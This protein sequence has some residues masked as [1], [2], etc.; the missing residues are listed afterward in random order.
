MY[1]KLN[2]IRIQYLQEVNDDYILSEIPDSTMSYEKPILVRTVDELTSWFGNRFSSYDYFVELLNRDISLYIYRPVNT[3]LIKTDDY[4]DTSNYQVDSTVYP[5]LEY[6]EF[7]VTNPNPTTKYCVGGIH[8][9]WDNL[10]Y[11]DL[12]RTEF[13]EEP[14]E[15]YKYNISGTWYTFISGTWYSEYDSTGEYYIYFENTWT[16]L[17]DLPQ[18]IEE[19]TQSQ[20]NRDTLVI[21][22]PN[23]SGTI[24]Y[25]YPEYHESELGIYSDDTESVIDIDQTYPMY[26]DNYV[27]DIRITNQD[28]FS[29]SDYYLILPSSWVIPEIYGREGFWRELTDYSGGE[30][31]DFPETHL[32]NTKY[33]INSVW[34]TWSDTLSIWISSKD[35]PGKPINY[36]IGYGEKMQLIPETY[37][38]SPRRIEIDDEMDILNFLEDRLGYSF[39][40]RLE[41]SLPEESAVG[42]KCYYKGNE[43]PCVMV[44]TKTESGWDSNYEDI[45]IYSSISLDIIDSYDIP[46]FSIESNKRESHI[47]LT[48]NLDKSN[49]GIEVWSKTIGK[50]DP[51]Y[52]TDSI[53]IQIEEV[54]EKEIYQITIS[55][56]D[57][58]ETYE[59]TLYPEA[60]EERLD[61]RI[62]R[63]SK[64]VYIRFDDY[65]SGLRTG[66][67]T[68]WGSVV[69]EYN[70]SMYWK[71]LDLMINTDSIIPDYLLVPDK[72]VWTNDISNPDYLLRFLNY[73]KANSFQVLIQNNGSDYYIE[74]VPNIDTVDWDTAQYNVLYED[75][76]TPEASR[77]YKKTDT[78]FEEVIDRK[79]IEIAEYGGDFYYNYKN[80]LDNRLIY[81]FLGMTVYGR[82]RPAY[83]MYLNSWV[84]DT[85]SEST[86][87]INYQTLSNNPYIDEDFENLLKEYKSNYLICNNQI[88]YYKGYQNGKNYNSTAWMRFAIGRI[89]RDLERYKWNYLAKR[90]SVDISNNINNLFQDIVNRFSIINHIKIITFQFD[91]INQKVY[92]KLETGV[93]DL[94]DNNISLDIIINYKEE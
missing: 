71:A 41:E 82:Y 89:T 16:P 84:N 32:Q 23:Y 26:S 50:S 78:G 31:S 20:E 27:Y 19:T 61:Y 11:D 24:T 6:L 21:P 93:R 91:S 4:V 86:K 43:D 7:I 14:E 36:L 44:Y 83:Y 62:S 53:S 12:E 81:F 92:I 74:E 18:N 76:S 34:W 22:K 73:A 64:L 79:V 80:D 3:D 2:T 37:I 40:Y 52:D 9:D 68:L 72:S 42:K 48:K 94:V 69:E 10:Q 85:Y 29:L 58:S 47:Q 65:S 77:Y 59:G 39:K 63:E 38:P 28:S 1:I 70:P 56:F 35:E 30:L 88:Y 5:T 49:W 46:G 55:R 45:P 54:K 25:C 15:G 87:V 17:K 75:I 57:Y 67:W 8:I 66:S 60:G 13:P 90:N 33:K 51:E